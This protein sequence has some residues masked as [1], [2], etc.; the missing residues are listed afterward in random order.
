M[1][2]ESEEEMPSSK[3]HRN[4]DQETRR[5]EEHIR[6][7]EMEALAP[8]MSK[9][10]DFERAL[11][12]EPNNS[13]LWIDYMTH[14]TRSTD[15]DSARRVAERAIKSINFREEDEKYNIWVAW[16]NLEYQYGSMTK[17]EEVFK[18]AVQ[19]SKVNIVL[20]IRYL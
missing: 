4:K 6:E 5:E 17:L 15:I 16:L 11:L 9:P 19:E 1:E 14:Y 18:R 2:V 20:M 12:A 13:I 10:A 8:T 7:K 3:R